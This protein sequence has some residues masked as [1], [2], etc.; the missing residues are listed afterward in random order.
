MQITNSASPSGAQADSSQGA[1][2]MA[3]N[4]FL[5][6]LISQLSHQDPLNPT[7]SSEFVAQLAQFSGLE[8][9]VSMN[10]KLNTLAMAE[11]ASNSMS[12]ASLLGRQITVASKDVDLA[13][14]GDATLSFDFGQNAS[15]VEVTISDQDGHVLRV[16]ELGACDSGMS[17]VT[18][19]GCDTDGNRLPE[20]S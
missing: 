5:K 13:S 19:D 9:M 14:E 10:D 2:S 1:A 11:A 15:K 17:S 4:D 18:W 6:L 7:D 20:G 8:Q 3:Q 16:I 12:T